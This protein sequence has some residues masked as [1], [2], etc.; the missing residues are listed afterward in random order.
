MDASFHDIAGVITDGSGPLDGAGLGRVIESGAGG[1]EIALGVGNEYALAGLAPF[2]RPDEDAP[3]NGEAASFVLA[4]CAA[5]GPF[6]QWQSTGSISQFGDAGTGA[7][8]AVRA[9]PDTQKFWLARD[10][11]GQQPL[12]YAE[13]SA[14]TAFS[15]D[16]NWFFESG[17]LNP[18]FNA[19]S[20]SE[21]VQ[22]QFLT[23][24]HTAFNGVRRVLP[25]ETL[26]VE[27]G[28]VV[29]R[30]RRPAVP[31]S[32]R[33]LVDR[34][35][36]FDAFD[37]ILSASVE[38][39]LDGVKHI[40][41]V[42]TGDLASTVL[43]I[44][45]ARKAKRRVRAYIPLTSDGEAPVEMI[46]FAKALGFEPVVLPIDVHGF[47]RSLPG[48]AKALVDPV[49]DHASIIWNA[50]A[51][52][53]KADEATL[54]LSSGGQELFGAY[55]RYRTAAR[56][57]WM[58]GRTMRGR[59]H[60]QGLPGLP[61]GPSHWRDGLTGAEG[62]LR[63]GKYTRVQMLQLI[64]IGTWLPND[65]MLGEQQVIARA[66]VELRRPFLD[67]EL[68]G[69]A[70]S[71]A[72]HLKLRGQSGGVLLRYWIHKTFPSASAVSTGLRPA[73]PLAEWLASRAPELGPAV[74]RVIAGADLM[75]EGHARE[76]FAQMATRKTKRMGMAAWQ[77]LFF[78]L[79]YQLHIGGAPAGGDIETILN[80]GS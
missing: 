1:A 69:F 63:G 5:N 33:S 44:A 35:V 8:A 57:L 54:I 38:K 30:L 51:E 2:G 41:C 60:L 20:F 19:E 9:F 64:D 78:A 62:R 32:D 11:F 76:I 68:A 6:E 77:L 66:G 79:W 27:R 53:A 45:I 67:P 65:T 14:T 56:P 3:L 12:Y 39:S 47:F 75:V 10:Q 13:R 74:D 26:V 22:L 17:F 73:P 58:G 71:L 43:A 59:G 42:L 23:G 16:L 70:F 4:Q 21:L 36:A 80:A 55:G 31:L 49:G 48:I 25:G 15:T 40:G 37:D 61:E 29:D 18:Y 52:A 46:A 34:S 24:G 7:W 28:R 72:D 50:I